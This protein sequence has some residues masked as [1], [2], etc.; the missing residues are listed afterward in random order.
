MA[1]LAAPRARLAA[2]ARALDI[3][4]G[5]GE[6]IREAP[7]LPSVMVVTESWPPNVARARAALAP[8]GVRVLATRAGPDCPS[9]TK[10][11]SSSPAGIPCPRLARDSSR[12][13]PGG[14]YFAQHVGPASAFELIE[15][16]WDRCQSSGRAE[17]PRREAAQ[18]EQAGLR[19]EQ[20]HTARCRSGVLRRRGHRLDPAQVRVVGARL[21]RRP[22]RG[23]VARAGREMRQGNRS[24]PTPPD[25]SSTPEG[26]ASMRC[27]TVRRSGPS[28]HPEHRNRVQSLQLEF[29]DVRAGGSPGQAAPRPAVAHDGPTSTRPW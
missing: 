12:A 6:I 23:Q 15:V 18:A 1:V 8:R 3:E 13:G 2:V 16:F 17:D 25:T 9:R 20:L 5:G 22:V 19:V 7:M 28:G 27:R 21:H 4:T 11:S 10:G 24:S 26:R 29:D 14:H